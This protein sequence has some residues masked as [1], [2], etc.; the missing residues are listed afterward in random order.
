MNS[1]PNEIILAICSNLRVW[2]AVKQTS[3][4]MYKLLNCYY[5]THPR[6][7]MFFATDSYITYDRK[8]PIDRY[9]NSTPMNKHDIIH[10]INMM[11]IR[12]PIININNI[13][14]TSNVTKKDGIYYMNNTSY[15][16]VFNE[17]DNES[18]PTCVKLT[19]DDVVYID[20]EF[21]H[22]YKFVS[23]DTGFE[24]QET[25][26]DI[27]NI[28]YFDDKSY[29]ELSDNVKLLIGVISDEFS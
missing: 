1:L 9:V 16:R 7:L 28:D 17:D 15:I 13:Y 12:R 11:R 10:L 5:D 25:T 18:P 14:I 19:I 29:D 8:V 26:D 24:Y 21:T 20:I 27:L 6:T 22:K 3:T 23:C 2:R 4:R